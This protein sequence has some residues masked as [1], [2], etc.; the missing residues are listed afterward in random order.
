[1]V[2]RGQVVAVALRKFLPLPQVHICREIHRWSAPAT[3][4]F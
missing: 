4:D 2:L 3:S 1:M